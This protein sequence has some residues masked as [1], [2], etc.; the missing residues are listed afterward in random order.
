MKKE[1]L[2]LPTFNNY[3]LLISI[4]LTKVQDKMLR[5]VSHL[6]LQHKG[7]CI[8]SYPT[9]FHEARAVADR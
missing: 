5:M 4:S 1:H 2:N 3:C 9:T 6:K 7:K 8:I